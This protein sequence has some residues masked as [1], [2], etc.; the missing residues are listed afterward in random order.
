MNTLIL[1]FALLCQQRAEA[2][3]LPGTAYARPAAG[4]ILRSDAGRDF[5][6]VT[7]LDGETVVRIGALLG[8][9]REVFVP[10][11]FAVYMHSD[12]LDVSASDGTVRVTGDRV[13]MRLLPSKDGLLPI[14]QLSAGTGPL[15]VL[16]RSG[17]WTRV[18]APVVVPLYAPDAALQPM[19]EADAAAIWTRLHDTRRERVRAAA[20]ALREEGSLPD[21]PEE[22][23]ADTRV[24]EGLL[25]RVEQLAVMDVSRLDAAALEQRRT[26]LQQIL[27]RATWPE[28]RSVAER[29]RSECAQL[30]ELRA[31]ATGATDAVVRQHG[32][33][34]D[35]ALRRES[36]MLA[37]G[38]TFG[39]KGDPLT[40]QGSVHREGPEGAPVY[41]LHTTEGEILKLTAAP[42]VATLE[43]LVG[44]RVEVDGRRLLLLVVDGPVLVIDKLVSYTP[45]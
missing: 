21:A 20:G 45:R 33:A 5:P 3:V 37:L 6:G 17:D 22:A 31:Q 30:L 10:Q 40:R 11:G 13:N 38:L 26:E 34:D 39:G 19:S 44:K 9:Y 41:T 28:T 35:Q 32:L 16:D 29:L 36:R 27:V 7:T 24:Q 42:E 1:A 15:V 8:E 4:T 23:D 2:Q 12:Y 18:L 25:V 43:A 14:G